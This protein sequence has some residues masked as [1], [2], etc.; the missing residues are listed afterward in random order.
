MSKKSAH[1][2]ESSHPLIENRDPTCVGDVDRGGSSVTACLATQSD[3]HYAEA[4][5]DNDDFCAWHHLMLMS[6]PVLS[7]SVDMDL[8]AS[9]LMIRMITY[10]F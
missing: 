7:D 3:D 10:I 2:V 4:D 1:G 8:V 9:S 6:L 5:E